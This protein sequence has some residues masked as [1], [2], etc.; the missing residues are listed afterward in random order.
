M[1]KIIFASI[2]VLGLAACNNE[3]PKSLSENNTIESHVSE[4]SELK[5]V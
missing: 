4:N 1:K 2:L 3:E 5:G